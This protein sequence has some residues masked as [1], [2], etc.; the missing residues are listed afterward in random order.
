MFRVIDDPRD[1]SYY[2]AGRMTLAPGRFAAV[3]YNAIHFRDIERQAGG[4]ARWDYDV[5]RWQLGAGY[6]LGRGTEIRGE[7]MINRRSGDGADPRDNLLSV[8]WWWTF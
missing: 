3:R 4:R 6:R 1:I 2:V 8:Q 5:R 7:Y